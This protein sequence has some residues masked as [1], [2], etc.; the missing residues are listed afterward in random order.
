MA[1]RLLPVRQRLVR[2]RDRRIHDLAVL[3]G[4]G[5]QFDDI[6]VGIAEI[7]RPDKAV[8]DRPAHL[9]TLGLGLIQHRLEGLG[10][11]PERDVQI[12]RVLALEV[13]GRTGHFEEGEAGAV[14]HL[15][16]GMERPAFVYLESADHPQTEKILVKSPR[17][18][19][20]TAAIS[21]VVQPL[22]HP[23]LPSLRLIDRASPSF[24]RSCNTRPKQV[25][26]VA[27]PPR[28]SRP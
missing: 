25:I 9:S 19:G 8:V 2:L 12:Q 23:T 22:D 14:V 3:T 17:L 28:R 15:E 26:D 21:I 7:D 27:T 18:L 20:I 5:G 16:K 1:L 4:A 10:L 11:D 13:E 24:L 6:A